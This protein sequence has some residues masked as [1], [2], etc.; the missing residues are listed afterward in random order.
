MAQRCGRLVQ[1]ACTGGVGYHPR[2]M[3]P[4]L[5][6]LGP[7]TIYSYGLMMALAFLTAAYLTGKELARK[8]FD[9]ELAS[10]MV[11]WAAVG[12]LV[13]A[14]VFAIFDDWNGFVS[15]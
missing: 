13:G 8:G 3:Y 11:F 9:G 10:T 2:R 5:L 6:H 14:R 12:G 7:L 1:L 15:D 4:V